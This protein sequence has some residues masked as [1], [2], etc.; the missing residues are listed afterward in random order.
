M[1]PEP[2]SWLQIS[3]CSKR[4]NNT[5]VTNSFFCPWLCVMLTLMC[6]SLGF[7]S[8]TAAAR[9]V[10]EFNSLF[11]TPLAVGA[12]WQNLPGF[13][14]QA[15]SCF[16]SHGGIP[17]AGAAV[18]KGDKPSLARHGEPGWLS[19]L[20]LHCPSHHLIPT[21]LLCL[22]TPSHTLLMLCS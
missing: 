11:S 14:P 22:W 4:A 1:L 5:V 8:C 10:L 19:Q 3:L 2:M 6:S 15:G 17:M 21:P 12:D 13:V 20:S 18:L 9:T 16:W 7:P